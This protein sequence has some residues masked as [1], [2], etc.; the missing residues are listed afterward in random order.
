MLGIEC[1]RQIQPANQ[2]NIGT[3]IQPDIPT[4]QQLDNKQPNI[5]VPDLELSSVFGLLTPDV[6]KEEE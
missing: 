3:A 5:N 2:P 1:F 6:N 4:L